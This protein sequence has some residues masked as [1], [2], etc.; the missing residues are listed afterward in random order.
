MSQGDDNMTTAVESAGDAPSLPPPI[1]TAPPVA[2]QESQRQE[3]PRVPRQ[4][5]LMSEAP[6]T[7][8]APS[9][10]I[11]IAPKATVETPPAANPKTDSPGNE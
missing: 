5:A 10:I 6:S 7:D 1:K 4:M 11:P 9:N 2:P 3:E 8:V